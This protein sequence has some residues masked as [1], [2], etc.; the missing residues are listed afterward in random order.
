MALSTRR[1]RASFNVFGAS[2][3]LAGLL[4]FL[5]RRPRATGNGPIPLPAATFPLLSLLG[6]GLLFVGLAP[7]LTANPLLA[8]LKSSC[9]AHC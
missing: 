4:V 9:S 5:P 8:G 7:W 6:V 3:A 1:V 2:V